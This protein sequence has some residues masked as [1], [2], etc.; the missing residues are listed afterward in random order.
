MYTYTFAARLGQCAC[1][2]YCFDDVDDDDADKLDELHGDHVN[3]NDLARTGFCRVC[4][5]V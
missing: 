4:R 3:S 5:V 2:R 1:T